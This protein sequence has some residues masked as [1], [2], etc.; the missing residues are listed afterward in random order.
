M[1]GGGDYNTSPPSSCMTDF[2]LE[3]SRDMVL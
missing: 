1:Q 2:G 3:A